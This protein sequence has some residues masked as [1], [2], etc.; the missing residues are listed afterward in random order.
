MN[1]IKKINLNNDYYR[2]LF[3]HKIENNELIREWLKKMKISFYGALNHSFNT[4][5]LL[6]SIQSESMIFFGAIFEIK[7]KFEEIKQRK[8]KHQ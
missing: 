3:F 2:K 5:V 7:E 6:L 1:L 4:L 8:F